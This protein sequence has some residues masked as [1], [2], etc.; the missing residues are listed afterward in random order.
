MAPCCLGKGFRQ[1][2][3][4]NCSCS[5]TS[6]ARKG[7]RADGGAALKD[8][9]DDY[10]APSRSEDFAAG[11][12]L[13]WVR[14]RDPESELA[15]TRILEEAGDVMCTSMAARRPEERAS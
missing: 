13:L 2:S 5:R 3:K 11:A 12:A 1:C 8:L 15:A 4:R 6:P 14:C 10:T 7:R 9:F